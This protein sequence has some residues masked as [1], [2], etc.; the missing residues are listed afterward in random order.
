VHPTR[1][2]QRFWDRLRKVSL[3][4]G[5][6]KG[7]EDDAAFERGIGFTDIVKRSTRSA[8]DLTPEEWIHGR[9]LLREKL[10]ADPPQLVVFTYPEAA[11]RYFNRRDLRGRGYD[12][13]L[14]IGTA[15]VFIMPGPYAA[16]SEV[17]LV[18]ASLPGF[19]EPE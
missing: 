13:R 18:I 12:E 15:G 5:G 17:K 3:L 7:W 8:D 6:A 10:E 16:G 9:A 2:G 11:K 1:H 4:P 19:L 14:S